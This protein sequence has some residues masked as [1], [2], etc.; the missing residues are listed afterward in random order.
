MEYAPTEDAGELAEEEL[1]VRLQTLEDSIR[2][3]FFFVTGG[4]NAKVKIT[5]RR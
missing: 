4:M 5:L 2:Y 1:F 3:L